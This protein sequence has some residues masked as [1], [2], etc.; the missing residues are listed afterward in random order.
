MQSTK[1]TVSIM[2]RLL[3]SNLNRRKIDIFLKLNFLKKSPSWFDK[4][5]DLLSKT[6]NKREIFF[7]ILWPSHNVLTLIEDI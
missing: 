3:F 7:Q 1:N 4:S 6:Q 2:D 5:A